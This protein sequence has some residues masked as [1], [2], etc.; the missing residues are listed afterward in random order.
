MPSITIRFQFAGAPTQEEIDK[1]L[2]SLA[3]E[4]PEAVRMAW[5]VGGE[6][7]LGYDGALLDPDSVDAVID[8]GRGITT[9]DQVSFEI[10]TEREAKA[11]ARAE[12]E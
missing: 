6:D 12:E 2:R 1:T 7:L 4:F 8:D 10:D 3:S 11:R 5:G 9:T